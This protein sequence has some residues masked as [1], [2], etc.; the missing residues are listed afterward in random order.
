MN[1]RFIRRQSERLY[2]QGKAFWE[3]WQMMT[4]EQA[5][6]HRWSW[7]LEISFSKTMTVGNFLFIY[8]RIMFYMFN[9]I[10]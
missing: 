4:Y 6:L 7:N 2:G 1:Q 9:M 3:R 10:K 5:V 8:S